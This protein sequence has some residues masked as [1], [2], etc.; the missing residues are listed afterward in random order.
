LAAGGEILRATLSFRVP[1]ADVGEEEFESLIP[2]PENP[3]LLKIVSHFAASR[4]V[5]CLADLKQRRVNPDTFCDER[6]D[7]AP[8]PFC[9]IRQKATVTPRYGRV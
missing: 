9:V 3:I 4:R 8:S 7:Y 1:R 2:Q 6:Y 5:G